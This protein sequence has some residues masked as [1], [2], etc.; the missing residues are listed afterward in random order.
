MKKRGARIKPADP[1]LRA[2][3]W[4]VSLVFD[5]IEAVLSRLEIDGTI[6]TAPNGSAVFIEPGHNEWYD[7]AEALRGIV[8]FHEIASNR[9]GEVAHIEGLRRLAELLAVGGDVTEDDI[10]Q[11]RA[12]I[13]ACKRQAFSM[14]RSEAE[15]VVKV[16][17][18]GVQLDLQKEAA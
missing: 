10:I 1:L 14:R 8:E 18:I 9:R 6:T 12:D 2:E 3:P 4:R 5:P 11:A 13:A 17:S 7:T 16:V 15:S